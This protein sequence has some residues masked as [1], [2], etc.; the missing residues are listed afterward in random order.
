MTVTPNKHAKSTKARDLRF[1][2][3][4][5]RWLPLLTDHE[6]AEAFAAAVDAGTIVRAE[7][8]CTY[9]WLASIDLGTPCGHCGERL[10]AV[11]A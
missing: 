11:A 1:G 3:R 9:W 10:T 5:G 4:G 7:C 8:I 6:Q 2:R